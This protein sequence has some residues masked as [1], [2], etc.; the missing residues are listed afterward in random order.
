[1]ASELAANTL[2]A[3]AVAGT[4]GGGDRLVSVVSDREGK[5]VSSAGPAPQTA[6]PAQPDPGLP[7]EE[8]DVG[9]DLIPAQAQ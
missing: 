6:G 2:H 1:M 7:H 5:P 9:L 8:L 3:R 4:G